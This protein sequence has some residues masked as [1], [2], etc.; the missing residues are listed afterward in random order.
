MYFVLHSASARMVDQRNERG[1]WRAFF[2]FKGITLGDWDLGY[3]EAPNYCVGNALAVSA[4]FPIG[5]CP[6]SVPISDL[7]WR[8]REWDAPARSNEVIE[9]PFKRLHLYDGGLYDNLGAESL[10]HPGTQTSKNA[11]DYIII[12]D[13]G[14]LLS[15]S[16]SPASFD[17]LRIKRMMDI[18]SEQSRSL[19]VRAFTTISSRWRVEARFSSLVRLYPAGNAPKRYTRV[20]SLHH[21]RA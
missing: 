2:R 21:W 17:P 18:M 5:F 1:K 11:G 15:R 10:F 6:L 7:V 9:L 16:R 4:A 12:S 13:A 14:A 19:R 3:A 8:K 20:H